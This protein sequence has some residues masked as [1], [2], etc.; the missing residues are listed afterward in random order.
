M[1]KISQKI[2]NFLPAPAKNLLVTIYNLKLLRIR[3][4]RYKRL[5]KEYDQIFFHTS[6][7]E[8]S[9]I[10]NERFLQLIDF[11]VKN[12]KF[13]GSRLESLNIQ[14]L[15]DIKKIPILFKE[16]LRD[17]SI[18]SNIKD[19]LFI[20]YTGGTTGKSLTF[21]L[22]LDDL[23]ERNACLDFFR[24]MYGY[25]FGDETAWF[26]G[27]EIITKK[28][29]K[30]K[31]Y[32][33]KDL[34]N[35][36]SYYSTFHLQREM[37][38]YTIDN[39]NTAKPLYFVGFPSAMYDIAKQWKR[40]GKEV[41]FQLRAIFPTA[42]PLL[43]HQKVF[44][45]EFFSCPVPDQYASSEGAPF[46]YECPH[47]TLHYDMY[48]G[49]IE[50]IDSENPD[51]LVTSF[52]TKCMPLIRYAIGDG[53]EFDKSSKVCGC[54]SSMPVVDK[55]FGRS[56]AYLYSKERGRVTVS[57]ISNVVKYLGIIDKFQAIQVREDFISV[58]IVCDDHHD[59]EDIIK[60]LDYQMRYRLGSDI[61]IEYQFLKDIP[62]G[63]NGKFSIVEN[64][65]HVNPPINNGGQK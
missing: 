5:L 36:I 3:G 63:K 61:G 15:N 37:I 44:L 56:V 53:V 51:V 55:I 64:R 50:T 35:N 20:G 65:L 40:T 31:I 48:S 17:P 59:K 33:V 54:G 21:Y 10:Q 19:K 26:S 43:D 14:S 42:E 18:K 46:I 8:L 62:N 23:I 32:W 11:S 9:K 2:Y 25:K 16:N 22:T 39:L 4:S 24:G 38:N 28:E 58:K 13:H 49:I 6:L 7:D 60:E 12:N 57:N 45:E 47:G 34:I 29:E 27:K 41:G 1:L 52:T 30:N